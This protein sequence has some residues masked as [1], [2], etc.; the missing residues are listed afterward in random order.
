[1]GATYRNR[2]TFLLDPAD[3][4]G[5]SIDVHWWDNLSVVVSVCQDL[6]VLWKRTVKARRAQ[7]AFDAALRIAQRQAAI[8]VPAG[9]AVAAIDG[10]GL[11][12][13]IEDDETEVNDGRSAQDVD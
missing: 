4:W 2:R 11:Y 10:R 5:I 9:E 12:E 13:Y 8:P 6:C 1:M 3:R 7:K